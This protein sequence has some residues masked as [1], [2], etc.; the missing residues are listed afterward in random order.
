[1]KDALKRNDSDQTAGLALLSLRFS[2]PLLLAQDR[3]GPYQAI[4]LDGT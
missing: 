4:G 1:M 3:S 2:R